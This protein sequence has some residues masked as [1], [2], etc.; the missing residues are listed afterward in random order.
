[1]K[2]KTTTTRPTTTTLTEILGTYLAVSLFFTTYLVWLIA[3]DCE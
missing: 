3:N 1:M 2:T